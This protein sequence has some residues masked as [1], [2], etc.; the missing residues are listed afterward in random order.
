[1]SP[2]PRSA[3]WEKGADEAR[4]RPSEC[5]RSKE[6]AHRGTLEVRA[7]SKSF[8]DGILEML[9]S[10]LYPDNLLSVLVRLP[11]QARS[12]EKDTG[13]HSIPSTVPGPEQMSMKVC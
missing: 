13:R 10:K 5:G 9:L 8:Q 6:G 7:S 4:R 2:A 11:H 1:M 12:P 3:E